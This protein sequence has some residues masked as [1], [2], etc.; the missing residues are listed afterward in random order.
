MWALITPCN[1]LGWLA[2]L[3]RRP[4]VALSLLASAH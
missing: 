4:A 3:L 1:R 2:Q